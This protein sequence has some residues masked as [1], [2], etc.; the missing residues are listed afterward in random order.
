MFS[1][2]LSGKHFAKIDEHKITAHREQSSRVWPYFQLI[3]KLYAMSVFSSRENT[4]TVSFPSH[5]GLPSHKKRNISPWDLLRKNDWWRTEINQSSLQSRF[6]STELELINKNSL[7]CRILHAHCLLIKGNYYD[8]K[9]WSR[10]MA[11]PCGHPALYKLVVVF[12]RAVPAL[13]YD[14]FRFF[15]F[16]LLFT[17]LAVSLVWCFEFAANT[18]LWY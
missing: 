4:P 1:L 18:V 16:G 15:E 13:E 2:H 17:V 6:K 3:L 14:F 5:L 7:W 9:W 8:R 10:R 11:Q 12:T